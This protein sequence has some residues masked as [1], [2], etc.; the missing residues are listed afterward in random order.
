MNI[1]NKQTLGS[2][3]MFYQRG[4]N[5]QQTPT[6]DNLMVAAHIMGGPL[7][8]DLEGMVFIDPVEDGTDV[9]IIVFGLP[10]YQI[11]QGNQPPIGPFAFHIHENGDCTVGNEESPFEAAGAHWNPTNAPHGHHVGDFPNLIS[12]NGYARMSFFTDRFIPEDLIGKSV[13]LHLNPDDY[14]TQP[15]G[16]A[17]MRLACGV[18]DYYQDDM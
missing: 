8:P 1:I 18:I 9:S 10:D 13:V 15:A 6:P 11:G 7:A 12:S 17:G 14:R 5:M 2:E 3:S 4:Y 16:N